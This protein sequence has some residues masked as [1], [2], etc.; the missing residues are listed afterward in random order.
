MLWVTTAELLTSYI[1]QTH[2][3]NQS[4]SLN[5]DFSTIL[6]VLLLPVTKLF[7][8]DLPYATMKDINLYWSNLFS[9][10]VRE[11]SLLSTIEDNQ[12][13]EE[14]CLMINQLVASGEIILTVSVF[15][16]QCRCSSLYG[17]MIY[18]V[19]IAVLEVKLYIP[20]MNM[21]CPD[22]FWIDFLNL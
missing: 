21:Y 4:D 7:K 9:S 16:L 10:F 6:E 12:A 15:R 11:S 1:N 19:F 2:E 13:V 22:Y 14:F 8:T 5:H 17:E 18:R 20:L 3:V